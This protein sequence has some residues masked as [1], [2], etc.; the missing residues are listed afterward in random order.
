MI[1]LAAVLAKSLEPHR[2][3]KNK[4]I[5]Q[6]IGYWR[7]SKTLEL[8]VNDKIFQIELLKHIDGSCIFSLT[9]K[10]Y[11]VTLKHK[12]GINY[13]LQLEDTFYDH[14]IYESKPGNYEITFNG[15][16]HAA[17]RTDIS[18]VDA[19]KFS[20]S[21]NLSTGSGNIF[22]RCQA[23]SSNLLYKMEIM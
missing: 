16:T 6:A 19:E 7:H 22:L 2:D 15:F 9:D 21:A 3:Q 12:R 10:M 11:E 17:V 20:S 4:N 1:I 8:I 5:W 23:R 13:R 14:A 18:Y